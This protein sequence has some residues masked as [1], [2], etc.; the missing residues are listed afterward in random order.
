MADLTA[1]YYLGDNLHSKKT[2]ETLRSL[3]VSKFDV[4]NMMNSVM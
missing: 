1:F 2:L 4:V 3:Y